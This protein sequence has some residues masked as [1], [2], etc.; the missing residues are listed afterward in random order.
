MVFDA[1]VLLA[2]PDQ[3][4]SQLAKKMHQP[5]MT[6]VGYMYIIASLNENFLQFC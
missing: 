2:T 5:E 3:F 1:G 4:L 6:T